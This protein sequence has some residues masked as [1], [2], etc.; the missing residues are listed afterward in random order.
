MV[1]IAFQKLQK[2]SS[3]G[4]YLKLPKVYTK[5]QSLDHTNNVNVYRTFI[6]GKD[7]LIMCKDELPNNIEIK[8]NGNITENTAAVNNH[9]V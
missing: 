6:D 4:Y 9:A 2:Y 8:N 3:I 7:C 1:K 5:D